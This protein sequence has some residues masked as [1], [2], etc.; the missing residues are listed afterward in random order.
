MILSE[1]KKL[2]PKLDNVEFELEN[3]TTVPAHFHVT[4]VGMNTKT[5]IDCGGRI[6]IEKVV[7]FQLWSADDVD[8][9]LKST[10]LLDIIH[11]SE[12]KLKVEDLEIEVEY[13]GTTINKYGLNI[14]DNIFIL[15]NKH[16]DCLAKD[17]CGI[18]DFKETQNTACTSGSSCC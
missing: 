18:P 15:I 11:L 14:R 13:Q 12:R 8:H 2:L 1:L 16:T 7:S 9:R 5:Y 17:K 10:N 6:R 3:G 4:E